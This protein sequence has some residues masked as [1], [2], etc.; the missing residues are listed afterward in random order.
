M[1]TDK[2]ATKANKEVLKITLKLKE[3]EGLEEEEMASVM[4]CLESDNGTLKRKV[5]KSNRSKGKKKK[6]KRQ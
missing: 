1:K 4:K 3:E 2:L 5:K 6:R